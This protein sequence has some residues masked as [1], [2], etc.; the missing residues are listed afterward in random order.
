MTDLISEALDLYAR[1]F[2]S[3]L[4]TEMKTV[5]MIPKLCDALKKANAEIARLKNI[6]EPECPVCHLINQRVIHDRY[7]DR[8]GANMTI[9]APPANGGG[10]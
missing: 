5:Y 9:S 7:C 1:S 4:D 6:I 8:C 2:P 10:K 3:D